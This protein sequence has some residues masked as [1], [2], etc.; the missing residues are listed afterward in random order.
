MF[1][2]PRGGLAGPVAADAAHAT[3][4]ALRR[5]A[6]RRWAAAC[7]FLLVPLSG[8]ASVE[9]GPA[10]GSGRRRP[11]H[12]DRQRRSSGP[13]PSPV[14]VLLA[15]VGGWLIAGRF[16]RPLRTI[17]ATARDISATNLNERVGAEPAR[18]RVRRTRRDPR[19]P[20][21]PAGG[22]VRVAAALRGQRVAR[23]AHAAH[24][25]AGPAPGRA[26]RPR[27]RPRRRC[28]RRAR[29]C[30]PWATSRSVSSR[31]CS[32]W[33]PARAA[34][35]SGSRSTWRS[36]PGTWSPSA[37]RK[38]TAGASASRPRSP[39]PRRQAIRAWSRASSR[40]SSTTRCATT[41]PAARVEIIDGGRRR[42]G[43]YHGQQHRCR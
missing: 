43:D 2:L 14:V 42:P 18:R 37:A 28:G 6:R 22:V 38:R 36:S 34:S 25:G 29:R 9:A 10:L 17:T 11:E 35:S 21:R 40:T 12:I 5:A 20:V 19:R 41:P 15:L 26:R 13:S 30:W 1:A 23:A 16:L 31:R 8:T 4:P 7:S 32:R 33:P 24:R 27:R 3:H 39:K